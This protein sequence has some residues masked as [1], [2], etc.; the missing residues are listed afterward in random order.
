MKSLKSKLK[1]NKINDIWY[2]TKKTLKNEE[3]NNREKLEQS[4]NVFIL[5][6]MV[7][8]TKQLINMM[9]PIKYNI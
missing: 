7:R 4:R 1:L 5:P 2:I 6:V 9:L 8:F 3:K